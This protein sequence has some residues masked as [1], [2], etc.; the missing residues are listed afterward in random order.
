MACFKRRTLTLILAVWLALPSLAQAAAPNRDLEGIRKKIE[1]EK[2][3]L[4]Q[5]QVKEGSVLEALGNI[6]SELDQRAKE[7]KLANARLSSVA[8][9]LAMHWRAG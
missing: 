8:S 4:S 6:Q 1:S 3:G 2:K 9:E 5:L 7:L